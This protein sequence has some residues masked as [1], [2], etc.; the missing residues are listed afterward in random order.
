M[1]TVRRC[2]FADKHTSFDW[3]ERDA[4]DGY[5]YTAPVGTYPPGASPYGCLDMQ[6]NVREICAD[7]TDRAD[8][9]SDHWER[10]THQAVRGA[11]WDGIEWLHRC[12][13]RTGC[14][15][16]DWGGNTQGFRCAR[17]AVE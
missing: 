6:G 4:D 8:P 13:V 14:V 3:S 15:P 10:P 5:A 16:R 9:I 2:N 7:V 1:K 11:S 12:W 17:D